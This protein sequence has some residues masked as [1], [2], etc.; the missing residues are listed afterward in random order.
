MFAQDPGTS[1][2]LN[3][4]RERLVVPPVVSRAVPMFATNVV[5]MGGEIRVGC[6]EG[7]W[8][9]VRVIVQTEGKERRLDGIEYRLIRRGQ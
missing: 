4:E 6:P 2:R 5:Q 7:R 3:D 1:V 9:S 8:K